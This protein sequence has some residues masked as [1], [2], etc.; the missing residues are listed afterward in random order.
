MMCSKAVDLEVWKFFY[1]NK[2]FTFKN[3]PE[4]SWFDGHSREIERQ[5]IFLG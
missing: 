5:I 3:L 1:D 2:N 4:S